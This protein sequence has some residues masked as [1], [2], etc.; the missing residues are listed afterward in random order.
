MMAAITEACTKYQRGLKMDR[1]V[2]TGPASPSA[3]IIRYRVALSVKSP[4]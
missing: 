4:R 2:W 1:T 3:S